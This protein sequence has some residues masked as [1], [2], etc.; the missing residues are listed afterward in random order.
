PAIQSPN[1]DRLPDYV[2]VVYR[3]GNALY[4]TNMPSG[5]IGYTT[6]ASAA[7][8]DETFY[9][10]SITPSLLHSGNNV[11]AVEIHQAGPTSSDISFDFDLNATIN[12][13]TTAPA[14]PS[15]LLASAV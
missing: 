15:S 7:I 2:S 3:N 10:T 14:A 11:I 13:P 6:A 4:R 12:A 9:S 1:R 8:E 5:T